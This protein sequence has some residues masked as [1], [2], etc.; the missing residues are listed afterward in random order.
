MTFVTSCQLVLNNKQVTD[1]KWSKTYDVN[2]HYYHSPTEIDEHFFPPLKD[3]SKSLNMRFKSI[4]IYL[5]FIFPSICTAQ[6]MELGLSAGFGQYFGDLQSEYEASENHAT[7][8][9]FARYNWHRRIAFKAQFSQITLT[10]DDA[11]QKRLN[12][13]ESN[14]NL[15]F[16]TK[17]FELG[18]Q[19][20][21]NIIKLDIRDDKN[22]APYIFGGVAL[23]YSNPRAALGDQWYDLQP[24]GTEGQTLE[25]GKKYS[26]LAVA[27]PIGAGLKISLSERINM[28]FNFGYRFTLTDYLD[29]VSGV[30]PNLV[31]LEEQNPIA[32]Q[33]SFRSPEILPQLAGN[34]VGKTRGNPTT[35]DGYF[36]GNITFSFNLAEGYDL[37]FDEHFKK[38]SP[39]YQP[40]QPTLKSVKK[41]MRK[42]G[43]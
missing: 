18:I 7:F 24:L 8:G 3:L 34:P 4:V 11:N 9:I 23:I 39:N 1:F 12:S 28:G 13:F 17:L 37:E 29:D 15:S 42:S 27:F 43:Q 16:K 38:F 22:T 26:K 21:W 2:H 25:G 36:I 10:G 31:L 5:V 40:K 41:E 32:S 35:K 14:R 19:G 20:E 6:Y 30:Y 33:L